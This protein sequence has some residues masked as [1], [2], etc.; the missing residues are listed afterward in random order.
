MKKYLCLI[1]AVVLCISANAV[2]YS[3]VAEGNWFYPYVSDLSEK[4]IIT[5]YPDGSFKPGGNVTLGEALKL[6]LLAAG[7][8]AQEPADNHWAGGYLKYALEKGYIADK[9]VE[10]LDE[11]VDRLTIVQTAAKALELSESEN[12]TPFSDTDDALVTAMVDEG[13]IEGSI[14]LSGNKVFDPDSFLTRA[15]VSAIVY[16]INTANVHEGQIKYRDKWYDILPDVPVSSYDTSLFAKDENGIMTY[17]DESR[18]THLGIDVSSHQGEIDWQKVASSGVGFVFVRVGYRGYGKSGS[19]NVDKNYKQNIEG[20]KSAGLKVGVYFF[21]Q[22]TSMTEAIEEARMTLD[23]IKD[24]E[25]DYPIVFDWEIIGTASARTDNVSSVT[26]CS[27]ANAFCEVIKG[28]GYIPMVYFNK[29]VG[30][31]KYDLSTVKDNYFWF[32]H[33]SDAP[34]FYYDFDIWQYTASG[35]VDGIKGDVDMNI[36]FTDLSVPKEVDNK[37]D[38]TD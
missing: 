30:Y 19:L 35:R 26:L 14:D 6:I 10:N 4:N 27:A 18:Q 37:E 20:A 22:A 3:D 29:H 8:P 32:A 17:A 7:I 13:I 21:S 23:L 33:Y 31:T 1:L 11:Y 36:S 24:Y 9:T 5:G 15:E 25:I 16:R 2:L 34:D 38:Y 12:E 28:A